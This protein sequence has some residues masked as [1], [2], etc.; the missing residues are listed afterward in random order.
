MAESE[1][2]ESHGEGLLKLGQE[3]RGGFGE[4]WMWAATLPE[5]MMHGVL[6]HYLDSGKSPAAWSVAARGS[7]VGSKKSEEDVEAA[8]GSWERV[9]KAIY[10][11]D[12]S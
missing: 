12:I 10:L 2:F 3:R 6:G 5:P 4:L 11:M 9:V 7:W 8:W 1:S